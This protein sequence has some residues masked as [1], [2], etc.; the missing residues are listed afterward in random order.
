LSVAS[1]GKLYAQILQGAPFDVLLSADRATPAALVAAGY[2][3]DASRF[4]YAR[5][6]LVLWSA[7]AGDA[8]ER[9]L[10]GR[11]R[12]LAIANPRLAPYGAAAEETLTRLDVLP[13]IRSR[14]VMGE[15]IAQT[16]Q[17]VA[18]GNATLGL[19]AAS[20]VLTQGE[21]PPGAWLVPDRL[22]RPI[23]QDAVL[24]DHGRDNSAAIALLRFLRSPAAGAVMRRHG[25]VT[26]SD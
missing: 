6:R 23:D 15:N 22:H 18:T 11:F 16:Y 8:R 14:L 17:F 21:V 19:L 24:L 5:G 10:Q 4:T 9:L 2:A 25:Y 20:Q 7:V 26:A 13:A 3:V 1:S 12:K